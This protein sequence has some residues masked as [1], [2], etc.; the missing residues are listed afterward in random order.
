MSSDNN[1]ILPSGRDTESPID[2]AVL[3]GD[4]GLAVFPTPTARNVPEPEAERKML[5]D[6]HENSW[7][8]PL[9]LML[10]L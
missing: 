9:F 8:G 10:L 6:Y 4:G 1:N 5:S 3:L 7:G 2:P